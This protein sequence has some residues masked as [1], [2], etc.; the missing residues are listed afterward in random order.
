L[1]TT[2]DSRILTVIISLIAAAVL[3]TNKRMLIS[4]IMTALVGMMGFAFIVLALQQPL[5]ISKFFYHAAVPAFPSG[6]SLL[7]LGLIGTTIVPYNIFLGSGISK[8]RTVP[9][10]RVGLGVS[11]LI[12][13]FITGAI[14]IAGTSVAAFASFPELG[15]ALEEQLGQLGPLML[16]VGLFAAGLSSSITAPYAS[17]IIAATAFGWEDTRKIR[18]VWGA[19]L[20]TGF[21]FGI[22]GIKPVPV[23]LLVQ[24]L[25]GLILPLLAGLLILLINNTSLISKHHRQNI[26]M[27]TLLLFIFGSVLLLGL[28]QVDSVLEAS[29][30]FTARHF[31]ALFIIT[32]LTVA[33]MGFHVL[34][35]TRKD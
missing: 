21:L 9:L 24:A 13:G 17:A 31:Q 18:I 11:V 20:I 34:R 8:G 35:S 28:N 29:G 23:I 10:M 14:L 22:S 16:G 12:G 7:I 27:N 5:S 19:V 32:G 3:W 30:L 1:L 15:L 6:S 25:N 4:W 33:V 2:I 26:L